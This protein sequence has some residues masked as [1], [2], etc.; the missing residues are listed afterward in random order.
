MPTDERALPLPVEGASALRET[1]LIMGEHLVF[2]DPHLYAEVAVKV[3]EVFDEDELDALVTGEV[4]TIHLTIAE[5]DLLLDGL[6]FTEAASV[7]LPWYPM[8]IE[9][10]RFVG[11]QLLGLFSDDEWLAW[12]SGER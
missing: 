3:A 7:D 5:A 9:T 8:V 10:V 6:R 12:H 2:G 11:D 1:L 4:R